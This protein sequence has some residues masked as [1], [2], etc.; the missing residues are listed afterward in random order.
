MEELLHKGQL[1]G[2]EIGEIAHSL[3]LKI[4]IYQ[5]DQLPRHLKKG[6]YIILLGH[7]HGHWTALYVLK[8]TAAY[9]DSFATT[10]PQEVIDAVGRRILFFS[11]VEQQRLNMNHCGQFSLLFLAKMNYLI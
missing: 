8:N 6:N 5:Y 2:S 1:S 3:G 9:Y 11:D 10:P 4:K 7:G